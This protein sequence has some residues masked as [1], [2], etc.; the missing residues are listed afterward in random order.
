MTMKQK[1]IIAISALALC[2]A[3]VCAQADSK[4][5][6]LKEAAAS[7]NAK[8]VARLIKAD[9]DVNT[10][11]YNGDTALMVAAEYNAADTTKLLIKAKADINAKN[12]YKQTA[13]MLAAKHNAA[14]TAKL[15]I[16]AKA[17]V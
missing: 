8:E 11:N 1:T 12:R 16:K 14:D 13:L 6:A 4:S 10:K 7:N 5:D 9:A 15:L 3:A 2:V 17:D